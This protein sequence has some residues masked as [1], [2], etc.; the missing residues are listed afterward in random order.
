MTRFKRLH[1]WFLVGVLFV[2]TMIPAIPV[3]TVTAYDV[4][5]SERMDG[6]AVAGIDAL[7]RNIS[8]DTLQTE[9]E[10]TVA[11]LD[12]WM[13]TREQRPPVDPVAQTQ[14][15]AEWT[16][17]V[18]VAADNNLEL[19]GLGDVNEMEAVGSSPQVIPFDSK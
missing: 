12:D 10:R 19:A 2:V 4:G 18:Y 8:P 1:G 9:Y 3:T 16:V 17:M 6:P 14:V 5:G 11:W 15:V 7:R 13:Q